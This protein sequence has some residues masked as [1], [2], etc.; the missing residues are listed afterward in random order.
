[1]FNW[2]MKQKLSVIL[3]VLITLWTVLGSIVLS[4]AI[5]VYVLAWGVVLVPFLLAMKYSEN[6]ARG[7]N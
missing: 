5:C 3:T 1:M 7:K 6:K 2:Y 4:P